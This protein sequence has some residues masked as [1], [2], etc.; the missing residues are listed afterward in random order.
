MDDPKALRT[1]AAHAR[2]LSAGSTDKMTIERLI[3]FAEECENKAAAIESPTPPAPPA[4]EHVVQQQQQ[5]QP[6]D[7]EKE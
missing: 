6:D 4:A 2:R 5:I 1:K 3:A 7:D